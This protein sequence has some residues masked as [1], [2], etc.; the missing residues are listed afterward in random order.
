ME[1][2]PLEGVIFFQQRRLAQHGGKI[3]AAIVNDQKA[4]FGLVPG[5]ARA[6][7]EPAHRQMGIAAALHFP[8][9]GLKVVA[10]DTVALGAFPVEQADRIV[11]QDAIQ[12]DLGGADQLLPDAPGVLNL[13]QVAGRFFQSLEELILQFDLEMPGELNGPGRVAEALGRLQPADL[14][15]EPAAARVHEQPVP[16][17][18]QEPENF[19]DPQIVEVGVGSALDE[20]SH[21][22][23]A[24]VQDDLD[25]LV[26]R[27][28]G[29]GKVLPAAGGEDVIEMVPELV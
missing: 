15:K 13:G 24:A 18:L 21:G 22:L 8:V 23:G 17:H 6:H 4:G 11:S 5:Q 2:L 7:L 26:A 28:P 1:E 9:A 10:V 19:A 14:V 16:L 3:E 27:L 25:I 20:L 12:I 29:I